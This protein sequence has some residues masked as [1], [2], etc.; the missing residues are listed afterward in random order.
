VLL[1]PKPGGRLR[2]IAIGWPLGYALAV[3]WFAL[4]ATLHVRG[5]FAFLPLVTLAVGGPFLLQTGGWGRLVALVGRVARQADAPTA[6]RRT[7]EFVPVA[8]ATAVAIGV[9]ALTFFA[10]SPLPA[11]AH[12]VAYSED[13]VF[14][15]SLAADARNHWP[16]TEPWVAGQPM[17]YYTAAFIQIAAVNQVMGIP[18][19]TMVLRLF[20]SIIFILVAL[21]LWAL[22]RTVGRLP[23]VGPL[24]AVL[25]LVTTDVNLAA[26]K[27]VVFHI[28]PFTQFFLSPTFAFGAAFFLGAILLI[29]SR[30]TLPTTNGSIFGDRG[31]KTDPRVI[32]LVGILVISTTAAKTFAAVDFVG[33]LGLYWLW[34]VAVGRGSRQLT[35]CLLTSLLCVAL[36]YFVMLAGGAADSVSIHPLSFI[37]EGDTLKRATA[38]SRNIAGP[39]LYRPVLVV[40]GALLA[41]MLLAPLLG[42]V[43]LIF[44]GRWTATST[45]FLWALFSA[46]LIGYVMVD[47]LEG[48]EGVFLI[49]GYIALTPVAA[50][51]LV[52]L[53]EDI[54]ASARRATALACA[55]ILLLGLGLAA[56]QIMTFNG[57]ALHIWYVASYGLLAAGM[58]LIIYRLQI[59]YR[60][61]IR[62]RFARLVA[63]CIP[64]L[65]VLGL[66]KPMTLVASGAWRTVLGDRTS[67]PDSA[68]DYGM[69]AALYRGLRWVHAH[70]D[71]CDVLAVNNHYGNAQHTDSIYF[72]YSAFTERRVFLESW[73]YTPGGDEGKQP[74]PAR[75]ALSDLATARGDRE[76]LRKLERDGVSYVLIDKTHGGGAFEPQSASV[77]VFSN[78]ALDVFR[79][80]PTAGVG[81][82]RRG[83]ATIT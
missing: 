83:C 48:V 58:F 76:A 62:S 55:A 7:P 49:Y 12:S 38:L 65:V 17:R 39:A 37:N 30:V 1:S 22:G 6:L 56:T 28:S 81:A 11:N 75:L 33:G 52:C 44:K 8:I 69:T 80:L 35:C 2:T 31:G 13:N 19:S 53:W 67:Q 57:R 70:T 78:S 46:G 40:G 27:S 15:I 64:L 18:F 42:A 41:V 50:K 32:T 63:C 71:S 68:S 82:T 73:G 51:G 77:L 61:A 16:I 43:W 26:T 3:G 66:V 34:A 20:P 4:T 23:W 21:Q 47:A 59:L 5:L 24:A 25:L 45:A 10:S 14:D 9:M 60:T 72:Y 29:Q 36:V 54:P 79:L 74:F